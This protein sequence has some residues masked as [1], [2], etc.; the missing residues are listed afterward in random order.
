VTLAPAALRALLWPAS[1]LFHG[2]VCL[3]AWL[4]RHG[5]LRQQRLQGIVLSVGNLTLGGTGK[6]PMVLWL[7][8]R[9]R[10]QG[11]RVAILTRGYGVQRRRAGAEQGSL[12]RAAALSD[13]VSLLSTRLGTQVRVGVGRDRYAQGRQ[14]EHQGISWF[15]LDDGFQHLRLARNVDIVLI[16][17]TEPFGGGRLVPAG[18]LREPRSALA[19]ADI[20]VITRSSHAPAVEAAVR[21]YTPAPIFYAQVECE[22]ILPV[23][24]DAPQHSE[25]GWRERK[26]FAFC[27]IGNP[28]AF[29]DDLRRWGIQLAGQASYRDHHHYSSRDVKELEGRAQAAGAQGLIC[30]EKDLF[31]FNELEFRALPAFYCRIALAVCEAEKFWQAIAAT[32]DRRRPGHRQ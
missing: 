21:R 7:A 18:R 23:S 31:N 6:T 12:G 20:V 30:T 9:L 3:R 11:Q 32:A 25:A 2:L 28:G 5:I 22:A 27:A 1:L 24:G 4:Y 19:R 14:L 15:V 13:E 26:L 16:D 8:Q 17:A 29:F 10:E